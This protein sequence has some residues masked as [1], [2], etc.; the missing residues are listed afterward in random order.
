MHVTGRT[1]VR[2]T[3]VNEQANTNYWLIGVVD[4]NY[5][6]FLHICDQK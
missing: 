2:S 6:V 5:Y 1:I 4:A 3:H